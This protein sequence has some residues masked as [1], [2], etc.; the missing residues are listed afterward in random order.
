MD[1]GLYTPEFE[2]GSFLEI[3]FSHYPA[4]ILCYLNERGRRN[5]WEDLI[6]V[7]MD[8]PVLH[9]Q[10]WQWTLDQNSSVARF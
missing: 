8:K 3:S 4:G 10:N 9:G 5:T 6:I 2:R 1:I 7:D